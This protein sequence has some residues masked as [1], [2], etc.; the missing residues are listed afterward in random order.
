MT[1]S[2]SGSLST[3]SLLYLHGQTRW[4]NY[5]FL[6]FLISGLMEPW[7]RDMACC[8]PMGFLKGLLFVI[9]KKGIIRYIDVHDINKRPPLEDLRRFGET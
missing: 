7:L 3:T 4:V 2:F 6:S 9:D 8:G 1:P 5:G